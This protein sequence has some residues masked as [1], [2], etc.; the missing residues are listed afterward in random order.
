[1]SNFNYDS[2]CGIYCGACSILK[3]Y[4]TG[5]KDKFASFMSDEIGFELRC[6]GCKTDTVFENCANCKS[7]S[8]AINKKVERC[9]D[10]SDFPCDIVNSD[11][12]KNIL[13]KLPHLKTILNNIGT[14]KN[15]GVNKWLEDQD[16][17]WKCPDCQTDFSWYTTKCSKCGKDLE[18]I[19]D[20]EKTFD[21]SI[22]EGIK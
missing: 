20:Y 12:L 19:M 21:K 10:C 16:K 11:E 7:R 8:C 3:A 2:Y 9:I 14:I 4:Q 15:I 18:K 5:I 1:M 22:F 17:K 13:D 6:H